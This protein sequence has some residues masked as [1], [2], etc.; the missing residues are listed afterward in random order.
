MDEFKLGA[1]ETRFAELIWAN[2]P[3]P[4]GELVKLCAKELEWKKSTTYTVLKKLCDRGIFQN[5]DGM[6]S[7]ILSQKEFQSRQSRRF[8]E[9]TFSGSLP[10]FIAAFADGSNLTEHDISEIRKMI[11]SYEGGRRK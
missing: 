11:D 9:D 2:E 4:S 7:S 5:R 1:V 6:V 10:A 8:V 3:L